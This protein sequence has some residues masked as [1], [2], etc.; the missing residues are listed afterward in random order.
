MQEVQ[1]ANQV[2]LAQAQSDLQ[3]ATTNKD[4]DLQRLLQNAINDM[5]AIIQDNQIISFI[6]R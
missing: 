6:E 4:R 1:I 5:Q 3:A 2:N